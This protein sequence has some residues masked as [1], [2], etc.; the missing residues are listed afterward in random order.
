MHVQ[1]EERGGQSWTGS[2]S[3]IAAGSTLLLPLCLPS[4]PSFS[5]SPPP[6]AYLPLVAAAPDPTFGPTSLWRTWQWYR[7]TWFCFCMLPKCFHGCKAKSNAGTWLMLMGKEDSFGSFGPA[8]QAT[9]PLT[10]TKRP[11]RFK[12]AC[13]EQCSN[14]RQYLKHR[15][16]N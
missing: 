14:H 6:T 5:S 8:I 15:L 9:L 4:L 3:T 12:Y 11:R 7:S 10:L 1:G 13:L 2:G 16:Y